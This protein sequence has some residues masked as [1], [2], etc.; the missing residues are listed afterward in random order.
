MKISISRLIFCLLR[1]ILIGLFLFTTMKTYT[2]YALASENP[3]Q[4]NRVSQGKSTVVKL[5][6]LNIPRLTLPQAAT[7]MYLAL[8][9]TLLEEDRNSPFILVVSPNCKGNSIFASDLIVS[10]FPALKI[11]EPT[12][13]YISLDPTKNYDHSSKVMIRMESP[14]EGRTTGGNV[15]IVNSAQI[16]PQKLD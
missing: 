10:F 1:G 12:T 14:I 8:D 15:I 3:K 11:G 2:G 4:I 6:F 13:Q 7:S 16:T 9:V 5:E